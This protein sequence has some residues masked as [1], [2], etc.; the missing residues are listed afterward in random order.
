MKNSNPNPIAHAKA[1]L[2]YEHRHFGRWTMHQLP[3]T[4][5]GF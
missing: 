4:A 1:A 5:F 2:A 3:N